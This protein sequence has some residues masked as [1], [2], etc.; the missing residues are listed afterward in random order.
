MAENPN[1]KPLVEPTPK[2]VLAMVSKSN[3][4]NPMFPYV[5]KMKRS[6]DFTS[7]AFVFGRETTIKIAKA[8]AKWIQTYKPGKHVNKN[9]VNVCD[10]FD[11]VIKVGPDYFSTVIDKFIQCKKPNQL[12]WQ[13]LVSAYRSLIT[14]PNSV[15]AKSTLNGKCN[16]ISAFL[17]QLTIA[18]IAPKSVFPGVRQYRGTVRPTKGASELVRNS[19]RSASDQKNRNEIRFGTSQAEKKQIEDIINALACEGVKLSVENPDFAERAMEINNQRLIDL[20]NCAIAEFNNY[21]NIFQKGQNLM[22][23]CDL[24]YRDDML[25]LFED[26]FCKFSQDSG[27][28]SGVRAHP[29][30]RLFDDTRV[31]IDLRQGR[32]LS[33]IKHRYCG[34]YPENS[35][36]QRTKSDWEIIIPLGKRGVKL[37]GSRV[38]AVNHLNAEYD[39]LLL[40]HI[41]IMIDTGLNVTTVDGLP[42][43]CLVPSNEPGKYN[44]S[45]WKDRDGGR[46]KL[47]VVGEETAQIIRMILEMTSSF[48]SVAATGGDSDWRQPIIPT[49]GINLERMLFITIT[50]SPTYGIGLFKVDSA[51][52]AF[53]NFLSRHDSLNGIPWTFDAIRISVGQK[54]FWE[55]DLDIASAATELGHSK[56]S[57]CTSGYVVRRAAKQLLEKE[58]RRFQTLFEAVCVADI[59][60]AAK[61][62]GYSNEELQK[63]IDE[64]CRSGLGV[65]C[66]KKIQNGN[67]QESTQ[68]ICNPE[69][70]CPKCDY[71]KIVPT[72]LPNL[73]DLIL[74]HDYLEENKTDMQSNNPERWSEVHLPWLALSK[75][76]LEKVKRSSL[77]SREVL[78]EAQ[79]VA[80]QLKH[81][82]PPF[83]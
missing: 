30:T 28:F 60:G 57:R 75:A 43:D 53:D 69:E 19:G 29:F 78:N 76:M 35:F 77:V 37:F 70:D 73:L 12:E 74:H 2:I 58:I 83:I 68:T 81:V 52:T 20:R 11:Y 38:N 1:K 33:F 41:I 23:S 67:N 10:F 39:A 71:K 61:A 51:R 4:D 8:F 25:P 7:Y 9:Y 26:Y 24:S 36:N 50:G 21:W 42:H 49:H 40:G 59:P 72:S 64:A 18:G 48:R 82:C 16:R 45:G 31:P 13:N 54:K 32:L 17:Q 15:Y 22:A 65:V 63:I 46:E 55:G 44:I 79:N 47:A 56:G 62:L 27:Q 80:N 3:T 5:D 66:W 6:Y 34:I 14:D